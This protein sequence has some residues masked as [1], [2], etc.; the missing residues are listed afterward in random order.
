MD[1]KMLIIIGLVLAVVFIVLLIKL[2]NKILK[3]LSGL[4]A[5]II[6]IFVCLNGIKPLFESLNYG[7]DLQ[8]GFE[9]L[10]QIDPIEKDKKIDSDMVYNTYKAILKRIDILGV[11]EPEITIEGD[12]HIRVKLAGVTNAEQARN[13]ISSTATLSFRD[14]NDNLLMTSDVLGGNAKVTTD[15][16]GKPA[17]SLSIKDKDTFYDV[18]NRVKDMAN[19]VIVIWLDFEEGTD[20]YSKEKD[21]CGSL[22]DSKC[23]SAASV[24][25]AF[26]SDVIIEGNFDQKEAKSLVELINSGAL[27]TKL[28][29]ISSRTT[30]ATY[31]QNSLDKTLFAGIIGISLVIAAM[32]LIYRFAGF[33]AGMNILIYT[34]L[35]FTIFYLVEG[36]LTLPGIAAMLLGIGMAVDAN[37]ISFERIKEQL[38]IGKKLDDAYVL[39]NKQ[40]FSSIIDAN[41]TTVIAAII[42]FIFGQSSVKGFATM[43]IINIFVTIVIMVFFSRFILGLFVKTKFFENKL[44][45]FIGFNKKKIV[46]DEKDAIPFKKIDFYKNRKKFI[47][48]TLTILVVG[49]ITTLFTGFNL[50]VDFTGGTNITVTIDNS[51][52]IEAIDNKIKELGYTIKKVDKRESN[53]TVIIDEVIEKDAINEL[54]HELEDNFNV[55]TDIFAV[56]QVVKQ[57]L[58][59]NAIYSLILAAIGIVIYVSIR[60]KFNYAISSVVALIHDVAI[61]ILFFGI[62]N[63]EVASIFIAAILTIIGYSINATIVTFD[64]IRNNYNRYIERNKNKKNGN[65]IDAANL[66]EIVNNSIRQTLTRSIFTTIT[67]IVPVICLM[68]FGAFEI[69]NFNIALFVGF[70]AGLYS[71]VFISNQ[72]WLYLE[73]KRLMKSDKPK[74]KNDEVEELQIK[75]INC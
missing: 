37:V 43:L 7:L 59:K 14:S 32:I 24:R 15:Q 10:Y 53:Y 6:I 67:T 46:K 57:E 40:S 52:N 8:G 35:S 3:F 62:T 63:L 1:L 54:N 27:P 39:G 9:V 73:T 12:N 2:K 31:G 60:F 74:K 68:L 16:Y 65:K 50:G 64:M 18:T 4:V 61:V 66:Q 58:T 47:G 17:V 44:G 28:T 48:V 33:I 22:S 13:V 49:I 56:S 72:L 20:S 5:C 69:I 34:L 51:T 36:V 71:S 30:E 42:L 21:N 19:N 70:I 11:S 41:I 25:E 29:E 45:L 23:L 26:A 55:K 75:G 38:K